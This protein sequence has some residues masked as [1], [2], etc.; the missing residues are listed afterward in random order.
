MDENAIFG[1][2]ECARH[3]RRV[4]ATVAI[5]A[6]LLTALPPMVAMP[7]TSHPKALKR[8][9]KL[10]RPTLQLVLTQKQI[11]DPSRRNLKDK[12]LLNLID[13]GGLRGV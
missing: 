10:R 5:L 3:G 7:R 9:A 11:G 1:T 8:K 12:S 2:L 13:K 6:R 4:H